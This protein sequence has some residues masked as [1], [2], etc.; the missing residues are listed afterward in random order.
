MKIKVTDKVKGEFYIAVL[1]KT[2]RRGVEIPIGETEF[3][4]SSIQWAIRNEYL[5]VIDGPVPD[6][7]RKQGQEFRLLSKKALKIKCID[8]IINSNEVFFCRIK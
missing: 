4:D 8:R 7:T 1:K 6:D 5:S 2:F 3:F